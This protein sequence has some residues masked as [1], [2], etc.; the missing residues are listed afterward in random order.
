MIQKCSY[1]NVLE[2]F[3]VEPNTIHFIKEIGK[4]IDLAPTSVRNNIKDLLSQ[5]LIKIKKSRPFDG[6]TADRENENF[7][8]YKKIYNL[9]ILRELSVFLAE[10]YFPQVMSVYGSYC[11]GEDIEKSDIDIFIL[12]KSKKEVDLKKFEDRLK[13]KIHLFITDDLN[14]IEDKLLK[15]IQNGT[16]LYGGF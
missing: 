15:K 7:I 2:V 9:Y 8:F 16:I 6:F 1:L 12:S 13:R 3:F 5:N 11:R 14:K 10:A 4:R